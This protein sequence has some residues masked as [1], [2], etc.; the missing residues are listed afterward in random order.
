MPFLRVNMDT[1]VPPRYSLLFAS[2]WRWLRIFRPHI[3]RPP[4]NNTVWKRRISHQKWKKLAKW[5]ALACAAHSAHCSMSSVSSYVLTLYSAVLIFKLWFS[6]VFS[7]RA[8]TSLPLLQTLKTTTCESYLSRSL[9]CTSPLS[10]RTLLLTPFHRGR[11]TVSKVW[12]EDHQMWKA[13]LSTPKKEIL[14]LLDIVPTMG[15][16][17]NSHNNR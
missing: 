13:D 17:Q 2:S 4:F 14:C 1:N 12:E 16:E 15:P 9:P 5:A 3:L 11:P 7:L 8:A 6:I 10:H